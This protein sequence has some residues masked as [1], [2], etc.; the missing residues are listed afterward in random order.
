MSL[1][2][3][4]PTGEVVEALEW[5]TDVLRTKAGEQRI[6]V[7][8]RPRRTWQLAH[9]MGAEDQAAA[10]AILRGASVLHVPEWIRPLFTGAVAAGTN[11]VITMTTT[12]RGL[13]A[14]NSVVLWSSQGNYEV[15]TIASVSPTDITLSL[16][17]T[18]RN[19]SVYRADLSRPG[20]ALGID[21]PGGQWQRGTITFEATGVPMDPATTYPQY[22]GHD[23]LTDV[24]KVGGGAIEEAFSR[25]IQVFDNMTGLVATEE[26]RD[27]PDDQFT[28]R[29]HS[30]TQAEQDT[31][32]A[33][34]TSRY[35]RWL[36]FWSPTWQ[37]DLVPTATI[38]SAATTINVYS[39]L[40]APSLGR[41]T[42]DIEVAGPAANYQRQV[43]NVSAGAAV[44]GRATYNLTISAALGV[45]LTT[46]QVKR[47][48][49][50]RCA[51]FNADR[52]EFVFRPGEGMTVSIPCIEVPLP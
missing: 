2:P 28:V 42:F 34:I 52:I 13:V 38:T 26:T 43:T 51:R 47:I 40:G 32:R 19:A 45:T 20:A 6:R 5:K 23:L 21:R 18:A 35:G 44:G 15:C 49:Y 17:N 3:F 24:T 37:A 11:V 12:G 22:R 10:R 33:W 16:V 41:S 1:W 36:A 48:S 30:L 27:L 7:R 4:F 46:A 50:L 14:G 31:V 39:P 9:I 8:E 25:P 29:W